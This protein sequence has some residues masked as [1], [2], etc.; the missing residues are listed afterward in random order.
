MFT[1][2]FQF[3]PWPKKFGDVVGH[4]P[5]LIVGHVW[6]RFPRHDSHNYTNKSFI[7]EIR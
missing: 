6:S 4:H 1:M 5:E 3:Q 7:S 2:N